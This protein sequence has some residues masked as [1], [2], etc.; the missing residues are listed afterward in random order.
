MNLGQIKTYIDN[1]PED[2]LFISNVL[3][4][5]ALGCELNRIKAILKGER[6]DG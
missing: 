2:G 6:V 4:Q 5:I 1:N 3:N